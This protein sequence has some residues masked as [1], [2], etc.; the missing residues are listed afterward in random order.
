MKNITL[1]VLAIISALQFISCNNSNVNDGTEDSSNNSEHGS[2]ASDASE[3]Y[4]LESAIVTSKITNSMMAGDIFTILYFDDHG[5]KEMTKTST[6][7]SIMGQNIESVTI[8]LNKEGW[9]Y[10]WEEGK[11]SGNKIQLKDM[12]DPSKMD[13]EKMSEEMRKEFGVKKIGS[14]MIMNKKCDKYEMSKQ[15]MGSGYFWLWKNISMKTDMTISGMKMNIDVTELNENPNLEKAQFE[16]PSD[17]TFTEMS[18][19]ALNK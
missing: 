14:E 1:P 18:M 12:L 16:I 2:S 17:V 9:V 5:E 15:G 6:K 11:T 3:R 4:G 8:S 19:P 7:M 13:Y 10:T